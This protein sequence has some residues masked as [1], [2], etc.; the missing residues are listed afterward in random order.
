MRYSVLLGD[1]LT[2]HLVIEP[3]QPASFRFAPPYRRLAKRPVLGQHFEDDLEKIYTGKRN[4]LP[5]FFANLVPEG[6]LRRLLER[7]FDVPEADDLA[8]L[9]AVGRDLPGAVTV[10]EAP[11]DEVDATSVAATAPAEEDEAWPNDDIDADALRFSLAGVQ[12]KF[13]VLSEDDRLTLPGKDQFGQWIV[14]LD[15]TRFPRL[16]ENEF[17]TLSWADTAGFNVPERKLLGTSSLP[18]SLRGHAPDG[19]SVF[20]IR[21][22]DRDGS[23]RIHQEDFAQVVGLDPEMKYE[24][25]KYEQIALLAREIIGP[26][27]YHEVV[28]RLVFMVASGNFDAHLKNWSLR[29]PDGV[30]AE[31]APLYDQVCVA[32]WPG[33]V[34]REWAL[35]LAGPKDPF[36]TDER[37]FERLA[38]KI[39]AD[40]DATRRLVRET[41]DRIADAWTASEAEAVMPDNHVAHLRAYWQRVPL[42]QSVPPPMSG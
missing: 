7:T 21:R 3:N 29:Y 38:Q 4:R 11:D 9:A 39:D 41:L 40:P 5:P 1:Q 33:A 18:E 30:Q 14:K 16:V 32:A 24:Q 35:K 6:H 25:I 8:L 28:R 37:A 36:H 12:M 19:R 2:G 17:A 42:L 31:L 27:G 15:S 13:S 20:V 23:T 10:R 26:E 34:K 22:Y